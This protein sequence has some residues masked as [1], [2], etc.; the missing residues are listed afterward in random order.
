MDKY[1]CYYCDYCDKE[2]NT[3]LNLKEHVSYGHKNLIEFYNSKIYKK[4]LDRINSLERINNELIN[5]IR[6]IENKINL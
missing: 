1:K 5:R 3:N 4:L 6:E 2:F